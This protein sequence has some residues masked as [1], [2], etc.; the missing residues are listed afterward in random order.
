[1]KKYCFILLVFLSSCS[2]QKQLARLRY[3]CPELFA[4][5]TVITTTIIPEYKY[6]TLHYFPSGYRLQMPAFQYTPLVFPINEKRLKGNITIDTNSIKA[7]LTVPADTVIIRIPVEK[8][9]PCNRKHLPEDYAERQRKLKRGYYLAGV[10]TV[11]VG[12]FG[13]QFVLKFFKLK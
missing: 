1:M 3:K 11:I 13:L 6:D 7:N 12:Y 4:I 5:D 10:L 9:M 2:C 8:I